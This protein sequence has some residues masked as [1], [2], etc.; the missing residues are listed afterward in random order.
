VTQL[1]AA[2]RLSPARRRDAFDGSLAALLLALSLLD[3]FTFALAGVYPHSQ[4]LHLPFVIV[5]ALPVAVRRRWPLGAMIVFAVVQTVWIYALFPLDQQPPLVPFVQLI[6]MVYTAAAYSDGRES[7]AATV[8]V[9][10]GILSDI[11]TLAIGKP[12]GYV[13]GPNIAVAVAFG[14]GLAFARIRRHN[15]TLEVRMARAEHERVEAAE[16]AAA[17][18]R[19]RIAR[20]LHDVISHDVSLMVLQASVERR[21]HTGDATTA[22]TLANIES[23]GREALAELRR[24]LG[25]L[26]KNDH[27]APL[28]PQPGLAQLPDLV[29]QA[30]AAGVPIELVVDGQPVAVSPGLDIAA[31]RIVQESITNAAKHAAGT[32]VIATLRYREDSLEIDVVND[33]GSGAAPDVP[34]P[35]GGHGLVGMHERVA[36]FGGTLEAMPD[37][38]GGFRVRARLPLPA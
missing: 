16:R 17:D 19:A 32:S 30:R 23:T 22:Q 4:W 14:I 11:P 3:L 10:I 2:W 24:M 29:E 36:L 25:V 5:S 21:V 28:R 15:E 35:R 13:A 6:V 33:G 12:L 26:H 18:E 9:A 7:R 20:E 38:G 34:L 37:D 1:T 27:D 31:Y 8:V